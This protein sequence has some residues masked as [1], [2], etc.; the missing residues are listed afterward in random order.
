MARL[1]GVAFEG[2]GVSMSVK[3]ISSGQYVQASPALD[4]LFERTESSLVGSSDS[5]LMRPDEAAAMRRVELQVMGHTTPQIHDHRLDLGGRR[6]DFTLVRLPLGEH[7]LLTLWA[8]R[9]VERQREA[10]LQK[11]LAQIE[12]HQVELEALRRQTP[13]GSG[14]DEGSGLQ[15]RSLF[16]E[17]L[18]REIDLSTREHREFAMVMVSIDTQGGPAHPMQRE[19]LSR[20]LRSNT[21]AMDAAS[22]LD[23]ERFGVLLSGVGLATAHSRMEHLRRQCM[24]Q[25]VAVDGKDL[26]LAVSVGVASFPHSADTHDDLLAS[27]DAALRQAQRRGQNQVAL[28][29]ISLV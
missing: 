6:R 18:Q 2:M 27:S 25:I 12:Q 16:D 3:Q 22:Q 28:A 19:A 26:G 20:L 13:G 7:Y 4:R 23:D 10:Q 21:R 29:T 14:R 8:E 17:L 1:L 24:Q 15:Q 5:E 11:A 9:S